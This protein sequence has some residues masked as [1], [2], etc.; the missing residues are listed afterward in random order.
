MLELYPDTDEREVFLALLKSRKRLELFECVRRRR[1][2]VPLHIIENAMGMFDNQGELVEIKGYL[3]DNTARRRAE[4]ALQKS[5]KLYRMLFENAGEGIL[6]IQTNK[7]HDGEII[8][9]NSAGASM[10][11]Y[12]VGEMITKNYRDFHEPKN[13]QSSEE[14]FRRVLTGEWVAGETTHVRKDGSVFP[15]EYSAGLLD[16]GDSMYILAFIRDISDRREAE[17]RKDELIQELRKALAEIKTLRGFIPICAHC[18]KIRND[19]GYWEQIESYIRDH[20]GAV[21]SHGI[22]P[23]C[24]EKYYGNYMDD[25]NE[26]S[27]D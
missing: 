1:D 18:K 4:E 5:E 2:G 16:L 12:E 24:M 3:F 10:H 19:R 8:A 11:G 6:L 13:V 23:E 21:F 17:N 7:D 14:R 27:K 26:P 20:T 22:C 25:G 9:A 15:V